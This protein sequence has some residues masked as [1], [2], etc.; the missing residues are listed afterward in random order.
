[1]T[2][3]ARTLQSKWAISYKF[4]VAENDFFDR[5]ESREFGSLQC[6]A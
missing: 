5:P 6:G 1:M 3:H 4:L 2:V